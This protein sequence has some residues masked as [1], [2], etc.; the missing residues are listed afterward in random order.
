MMFR[1]LCLATLLALATPAWA[2]SDELDPVPAH[3]IIGHA[4]GGETAPARIRFINVSDRPVKL[5][6]IMF[7]GSER[8]YATLDEGQEIVQPTYVAHRWLARDAIDGTPLAAFIATRSDRRSNGTA[9]IAI[10][11]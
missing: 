3:A 5:M 1:T 6:W 7:D 10:I 11:R 2:A 9:Q 4:Y 8:A